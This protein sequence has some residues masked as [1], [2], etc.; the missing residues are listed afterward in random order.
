LAIAAGTASA[1][2]EDARIY[3]QAAPT[4]VAITCKAPTP[5]AGTPTP[6]R[7]LQQ[8]HHGTGTVIHPR[9]YIL[10][11]PSVVPPGATE[12]NIFHTSA[13]ITPGVLL[14]SDPGTECALIRTREPP[15]SPWAVTP[16]GDS[17]SMV[18]GERAYTLADTGWP[19]P[20]TL[21]QFGQPAFS[22]GVISG[23]YDILEPADKMATYKGR[24]IETTAAVNPSSD[25]G[26]LLDSG[27]NLVGIISLN[28]HPMRRLGT[29]V[30]VSAWR[31]LLKQWLDQEGDIGS[32]IS[33]GPR[34]S[35]LFQ[36]AQRR[37]ASAVVALRVTRKSA[38]SVT[39]ET[40][41]ASAS[42]DRKK[43]PATPSP[44]PQIPRPEGAVSGLALGGGLVLT[45]YWN[46]KGELESITVATPEGPTVEG[47]LVGWD[48]EHDLALVRADGVEPPPLQWGSTE[49]L[50]VGTPVALIGRSPDPQAQTLTAG[51][52]SALARRRDGSCLQ[53]DA[54]MN[55]GTS[56]A[57]LAD[58]AGRV[59]GL[60]AFVDDR[61]IFSHNSGVGYCVR[62]ELL[63]ELVPRMAAGERIERTPE[64]YLGVQAAEGALDVQGAVVGT[65]FPN[66]AAQKAGLKP[67]DVIVQVDDQAVSEW[68]D[69]AKAIRQ[70]KVGDSFRVTV[71]RNGKRLEI[72]A[73]MGE[74]P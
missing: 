34:K 10:T 62:S 46:V 18:G 48:E 64:P 36:E 56:G 52:V 35:P 51:V 15:L 70:K 38:E 42:Q 66:T 3:R 67:G 28:Y 43:H 2:P 49:T 30:P 27:G 14:E 59:L 32:L 24:M 9:G 20:A 53:V 44:A 71:E 19:G 47:A 1:T 72:T 26:P 54:A 4:I 45:S 25:G 68:A 60:C 37:I 39:P 55:Y 8:T 73:T 6:V 33:P 23:F 57:P 65:V 61:A 13:G 16:L 7:S 40:E 29:A 41:E 22:A 74:R 63:Q 69:L 12:I 17:E 50:R 21:S 5:N 58:E 31:S 11:S